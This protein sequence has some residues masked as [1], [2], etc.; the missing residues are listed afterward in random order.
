[1]SRGGQDGQQ[2]QPGPRAQPARRARP[3]LGAR[4][5]AR[6]AQLAG[7]PLSLRAATHPVDQAVRRDPLL[8]KPPEDARGP[9]GELDAVERGRYALIVNADPLQELLDLRAVDDP[10]TLRRLACHRNTR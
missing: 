10:V 1:M 7:L 8:L 5:P 6:D 2:V 3:P 9:V 4:R